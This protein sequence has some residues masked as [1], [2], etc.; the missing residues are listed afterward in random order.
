MN[1]ND[2]QHN[3]LLIEDN[4]A[5]AGLIREALAETPIGVFHI[6]WVK[7]LADGLAR[8]NQGGIEAILADLSLPDSR[9]IETLDKLFLC[10]PHIPI[11][12]LSGPEDEDIAL[13]AVRHGAQDYLPKR[14]LDRYALSR[15][16][17]NMI[18]RKAT[19]EVL[20]AEK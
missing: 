13:Q 1:R 11:L 7:N 20:F 3:L 8:L 15:A 18:D 4:P 17:R 6:E 2:A 14:H 10:A 12:V 16:L 9:S 5:D 19:E